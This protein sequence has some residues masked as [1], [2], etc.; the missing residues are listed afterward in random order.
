MSRVAI[1]A[2]AALVAGYVVWLLMEPRRT[3]WMPKIK[4]PARWRTAY[5]ELEGM[6]LKSRL[7]QY[8]GRPIPGWVF[9]LLCTVFGSAVGWQ[10][11]HRMNNPLAALLMAGIVGYLVFHALKMELR[12]NRERIVKRLPR[13]FLILLNHQQASGNPVAAMEEV[14][15]YLDEPLR[16]LTF[17]LAGMIQ[18]GVSVSEA[19]RRTQERVDNRLLNEF[20]KD[21][22][23]IVEYGGN[24]AACIRVY[25][26]EAIS[27]SNRAESYKTENSSN[28]ML[29]WVFLAVTVGMFLYMTSTNP[30]LMKLLTTT[31]LGKTAV[32]LIIVNTTLSMYFTY[33]FAR[34]EV[35][36]V[37]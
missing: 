20:L 28:I 24:M 34:W 27:Q 4:T 30:D 8:G 19:V 32:V 14:S 16:S 11:N 9:L 35:E 2:V 1:S 18:A 22:G 37:Y 36:T 23:H 13:L 29:A 26:E 6:L 12:W 7:L 17:N 5:A 15:V 31:S 10:V 3:V 21:Y 25:V 33:R